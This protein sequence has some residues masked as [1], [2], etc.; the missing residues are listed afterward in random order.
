MKLLYSKAIR[1]GRINKITRT[2]EQEV[3]REEKKNKLNPP[4]MQQVK[5]YQKKHKQ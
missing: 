5:T 3:A 2:A 4:T 1:V